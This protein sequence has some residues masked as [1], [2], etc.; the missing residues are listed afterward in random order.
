M[1]APF[2]GTT[3]SAPVPSTTY[4]V[5]ESADHWPFSVVAPARTASCF[6]PSAFEGVARGVGDGAAWAGGCVTNVMVCGAATFLPLA[7]LA[8]GPIVTRYCVLGAR[9]PLAGCTASVFDSH[10]KVAVVAGVICTARSV[11][12]W[13]IG[14]LNETRMGCCRA[15]LRSPSTLPW[16]MT[17]LNV[18]GCCVL[19]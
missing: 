3:L 9:L 2:A 4:R 7:V 6:S 17:W 15:T 13:S 14:W 1:P 10:E 12:E 19:F 11:D 18:A 8:S 16:M 5:E